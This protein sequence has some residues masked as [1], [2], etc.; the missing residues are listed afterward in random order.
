MLAL[1]RRTNFSEL[2]GGRVVMILWPRARRT[3]P[4]LGQTPLVWPRLWSEGRGKACG[5][6]PVA[7][8]L[9]GGAGSLS[10][11]GS[12]RQR[13]WTLACQLQMLTLR[14]CDDPSLGF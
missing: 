7:L 3:P 12:L 2:G 9:L 11:A 14:L 10:L 4:G 8:E 13:S 5:G 1:A 6:H